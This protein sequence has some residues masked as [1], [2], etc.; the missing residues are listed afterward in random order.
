[1]DYTDDKCRTGFSF[2]QQAR[3]QD[4]YTLY[5]SSAATAGALVPDIACCFCFQSLRPFIMTKGHSN[6]NLGKSLGK[7]LG[8]VPT[9]M[10][11]CRRSR[12]LTP[13]HTQVLRGFAAS[14]A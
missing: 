7:S 9:H 12:H 1:M 13:E 2:G 3:M 11:A 10:H 8:S 4:M 5:R 14:D 6:K